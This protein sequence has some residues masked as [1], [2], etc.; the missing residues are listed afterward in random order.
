MVPGPF[1]ARL[2]NLT[3][4]VEAEAESGLQQARNASGLNGVIRKIDLI[5]DREIEQV[6]AGIF[7]AA[8]RGTGKNLDCKPGCSWCC[9]RTVYA[10]IPEA[11]NIHSFVTEH[12]SDGEKRALEERIE[13]YAEL[14]AT[15]AD[16]S[17]SR[18]AC[19]FLADNLCT[20]YESRPLTCRGLNSV[21]VET[22]MDI[23]DHP[24]T[25]KPRASVPAHDAVAT[26]VMSGERAA[27]FFE[28]LDNR[29]VDLGR[30]M[31]LLR[32]SQTPIESYLDGGD[33]LGSAKV[34]FP[35]DPFGAADV[36]R[37]LHP[38]F[39]SDWEKSQ[40]TG[41]PSQRD[42]ARVG[43]FKELFF[44]KAEFS[45][46]MQTLRG[47]S[48]VELIAKMQVPL[49]YPSEEDIRFWR[50]HAIAAL[51]EFAAADVNAEQA[52]NVLAM[53]VPLN[54][55]YQGLDDKDFM[56]EHSGILFTKIFAKLF[57]DLTQPIELKPVK[58]RKL[59]VGYLSQH[60]RYH[61]GARWTLGWIR[62]HSEDIESFVFNVGYGEDRFSRRFQQ[63]ADHYF[64]L[65]RSVPENARFIKSL[66]LD[67]LILPDA[68]A[69]ARNL[70]YSL[71]RLAP[72]Q[73]CAWGHPVT[74]GAPTM[75]YYISSE[76]ME[77]SNAQD[78]YTE[79]LVL[80]P[81]SGLC[82]PHFAHEPIS[83]AS[84]SYFGLAEDKP[85]LYLA[86]SAVKCQPQFDYLYKEISERM[87][88][89]IVIHEHRADIGQIVKK[90]LERAGVRTHWLPFV[91]R[92]EFLR[93][94]QLC[95][96]SL[97]TPMWSGGNTTIEALTFGKP[98]VTLPGPYMR[99]RHSYAFL[100]IAGAEG[101]IAK[102]PEDYISLATDPDRQQAALANLNPE[103]LYEDKTCVHVLDEFLRRV[104]SA[105]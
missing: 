84:R 63:E 17:K 29:M 80:L 23:H 33:E 24:D 20:I 66:D 102:D 7:E 44:G 38:A 77:P 98:V 90:R 22:C 55:A 4:T 42:L 53:Q 74:T 99:S 105:P 39:K 89:P 79:K 57:P 1:E 52:F 88:A 34:Y 60:I 56:K 45:K 25:A 62:N 82:Y 43:D 8:Q 87:D 86:Q 14:I 2:Q 94:M 9:H 21:R 91:S 15:R 40:P 58:G 96:V 13:K 35:Q 27:L 70:Q 5:A 69:S 76:M 81:N 75:D 12:F 41:E 50:Q 97:D 83:N 37:N 61:S 3:K 71:F 16:L 30:A 95:D 28:A 19:P 47:N 73:C 93:L 31:H 32:E 100:K 67:V 54:M 104:T 103:A 72:V 11:L 36:Q 65:T 49:A 59:R 46:A 51:R 6:R 48:A 64:F 101:L 68:Q 78:Q 92:P 18:A 26:A 10:T 85:F